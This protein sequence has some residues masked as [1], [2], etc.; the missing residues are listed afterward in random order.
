LSGAVK[1]FESW[2]RKFEP[3]EARANAARFSKEAFQRRF[4]A[5]IRVLLDA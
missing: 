2:E 1:R 5:E 3:A 4:S